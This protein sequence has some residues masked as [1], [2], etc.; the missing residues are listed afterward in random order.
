[1]TT[2]SLQQAPV[3]HRLQALPPVLEEC[4]DSAAFVAEQRTLTASGSLPELLAEDLRLDALLDNLRL[5]REASWQLLAE[6]LKAPEPGHLFVAAMMALETRDTAR[7]KQVIAIAEADSEL[8][9]GLALA[10][11]WVPVDFSRPLVAHLLASRHPFHRLLGIELCRHHSIPADSP[12]EQALTQTNPALQ[13]AALRASGDIGLL[14]LL[15][16]CLPLLHSEQP[17]VALAAARA[18]ALMGERRQSL[19]RLRTIATSDPNSQGNSED[20]AEDSLRS[21]ALSLLSVLLPVAE[22]QQWLRELARQHPNPRLMIQL[23][24]ELGDP[25]SVPALLRLME[26]PDLSRLAGAAFSAITG[27]NLVAE[28][29]ELPAPPTPSAESS[30]EP[31]ADSEPSTDPEDDTLE[32]DP[33]ADLPWPDRQQLAA[34]WQAQQRHFPAGERRLAGT[35]INAENC[36]RQLLAGP[37]PVRATAALHLKNLYPGQPLFPTDAPAWRQQRMLR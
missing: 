1:M 34:W 19:A 35:A 37:G 4:I 27:L 26:N 20:R 22:S 24:G 25:A 23:A 17:A 9:S 29:M 28:E 10:L 6:A 33:D 36:L 16:R 30:A 32:S 5:H 8:R 13:L 11:L 21:Q 2:D 15:P 18:C 7:L 12:L 31:G 14:D 3:T